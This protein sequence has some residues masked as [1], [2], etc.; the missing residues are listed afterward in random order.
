MENL[1]LSNKCRLKHLDLR[2]TLVDDTG[3]EKFL[4]HKNA[5]LLEYL[6]ISMNFKSITDK[7]LEA[8]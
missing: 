4:K 6:D 7:T 1:T 3:M 8:L 5:E 2:N